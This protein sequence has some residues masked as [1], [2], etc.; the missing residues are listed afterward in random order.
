M[1]DFPRGTYN[2]GYD[3]AR[4]NQ[5]VP[6]RPDVQM[7][8]YTEASY[9][10]YDDEYGVVPRATSP[11]NYQDVINDIRAALEQGRPRTFG[12]GTV[13]DGE[14]IE[15]L[16]GQLESIMPYELQRAQDI[17]R[18]EEIRRQESDRQYNEIIAEATVKAGRMVENQ[19]IVRTARKRAEQIVNDAQV[20][21]RTMSANAAKWI[22]DQ[23]TKLDEHLSNMHIS[24]VRSS[25]HF[26]RSPNPF[27]LAPEQY[28]PAA[29]PMNGVPVASADG[30]QPYDIEDLM[31]D[32]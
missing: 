14:S 6:I 24:V 3:A 17:V 29:N 30:V 11:R 31:G 7:P 26:Q 1:S 8:S 28:Q 20:S 18:N 9:G 5:P 21:V 19:E 27:N 25:E 23:L 4:L 15:Y 22:E 32:L 12:G 16:L 10:G 13:V 2:D